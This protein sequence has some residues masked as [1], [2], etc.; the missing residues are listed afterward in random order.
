MMGALSRRELLL[1]LAASAGLARADDAGPADVHR[2]LLDMAARYE[3]ERRARFAA[4]T[5]RAELVALQGSL[6]EAF[7]RLIGGLPERAGVPPVTRTG[8]IEDEDYVVE[9]LAFESFP[10]YF[11][12]ALLYRP[13]K[14]AGP[15]P[16]VLQP[17]RPLR[18]R[19]GGRHVP[20]LA[21]QPGEA[22]L[23]RPH[24]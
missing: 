17:L 23:R 22:G 20:D 19:Q 7:L 8:Q 15:V 4:V 2:Q 18:D 3:R 24:V 10:G 14:A 9:K 5:T 16:G 11:V 6:R 21:H 1:G 13:K 12:P